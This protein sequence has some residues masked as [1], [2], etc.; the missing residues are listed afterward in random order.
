[1]CSHRAPNN[2]LV[3]AVLSVVLVL[4]LETDRT[5]E[6]DSVALVPVPWGIRGKCLV[7]LEHGIVDWPKGSHTH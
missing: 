7:S 5:A 4:V 1:M 6:L 2:A 3:R